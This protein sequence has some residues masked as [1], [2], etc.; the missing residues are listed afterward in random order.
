MLELVDNPS[1]LQLV[2]LDHGGEQLEVVARITRKL[3]KCL[4][5][6]WEAT[7]PVSDPG[8][9]EGGA[10]ALVETHA[11][12]HFGDAGSDLLADVGYLVDE[13]DLGREEGIGGELDHLG[14]GDVGTDY[15]AAEGL[16]E[17]GHRVAGCLV[18]RI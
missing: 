12:R 4:E 8:A 9:Q 10:D 13:G 7:T 5:I 2:H 16:V 17:A 14:A 1:L 3:L 11:A 6:L 18:A 15:L